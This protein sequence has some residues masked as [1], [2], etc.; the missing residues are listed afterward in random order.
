ME[1]IKKP[2]IQAYE[3]LREQ[4]SKCYRKSVDLCDRIMEAI[5]KPFIQA[6]EF[7]RDFF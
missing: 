3:F 6:Y 2:A 7:L 5:K 4:L 1:V